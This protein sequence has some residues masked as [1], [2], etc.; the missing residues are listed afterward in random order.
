MTLKGAA[1]VTIP[2][3]L[4]L[5]VGLCICSAGLNAQEAEHP[6][7]EQ[8]R[9]RMAAIFGEAEPYWEFLLEF[10]Q[11]VEAHDVEAVAMMV[12]YPIYIDYHPDGEVRSEAEFAQWYDR[13]FTPDLA[14]LVVETPF[15]ALL[16]NWHGIGYGNGQIW[17]NGLYQDCGCFPCAEE[18]VKVAVTA[19]NPG[20]PELSLTDKKDISP[21]FPDEINCYEPARS[22]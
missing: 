4:L 9:L 15:N 17:I 1:A 8:A 14:R 5:V 10:R 19:L 18:N 7:D 20:L 11:A 3:R 2:F 13:I 12:H 21:I 22:D 6:F 16:I